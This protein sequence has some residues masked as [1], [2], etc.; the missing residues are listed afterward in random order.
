MEEKNNFIVELDH[1]LK[2]HK[3]TMFNGFFVLINIQLF[4]NLIVYT[5][6]DEV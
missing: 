6:F 1:K 2:I 5:F 3:I 4:S